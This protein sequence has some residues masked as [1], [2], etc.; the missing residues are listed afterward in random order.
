MRFLKIQCFLFCVYYCVQEGLSGGFKAHL[1]NNLYSQV[2][3]LILMQFSGRRPDLVNK[4]VIYISYRLYNIL[5]VKGFHPA[6]CLCLKSHQCTGYLVM[7]WH[8]N[9][10]CAEL[11]G[12]WSVQSRSAH[13]YSESIYFHLRFPFI[14]SWKANSLCFD[15]ISWPNPYLLR[16][17]LLYK[18]GT[19]W[20]PLLCNVAF[21]EQ[22][23]SKKYNTI[24][25]MLFFWLLLF[26]SQ[27]T[28]RQSKPAKPVV[29]SIWVYT[30]KLLEVK[31]TK[32]NTV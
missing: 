3:C 15:T 13:V 21:L 8:S 1:G 18:G 7:D 25:L 6:G 31:H 2:R 10:L 11:T 22:S 17:R 27:R 29:S 20:P 19:I 16:L 32:Y 14:H 12:G 24:L 9:D 5:P 23:D 28:K 30:A 4:G 26:P